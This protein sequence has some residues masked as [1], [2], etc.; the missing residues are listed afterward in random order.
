[1]LLLPGMPS[2]AK[3]STTDKALH[4]SES[5]L[6]LLTSWWT[7][8]IANLVGGLLLLVAGYLLYEF[9]LLQ[10]DPRLAANR[11]EQVI[12]QKEKRLQQEMEQLASALSDVDYYTIF[13]DNANR[14]Q[15][16]SEDDGLILLVYENNVL[17]F[18]SDH[19][20]PVDRVLN[21]TSFHSNFI[22]E[23]NGWFVVKQQQLDNKRIVGLI[24]IKNEY[25]FENKY[26]S[27][28]FQKDL[29]IHPNA[30][31]V[32]DDLVEVVPIHDRNGEELFTLSFDDASQYSGK[33]HPLLVVIDLLGLI[34]LFNFARL[35]VRGLQW[36]QNT[37]LKWLLTAVLLIGIRLP[38][39]LFKYPTGLYAYPLF[40][41]KAYA[42]STLFPSLGDLFL[43]ILLLFYLTYLLHNQLVFP[44]SWK[45]RFKGWSRLVVALVGLL[46]LLA[47]SGSCDLMIQ[48]LIDNSNISFNV[49]NLFE[50]SM[51]SYLGILIIGILLFAFFIFCDKVIE[52][53]YGLGSSMRELSGATLIAVVLYGSFIWFSG[54]LELIHLLWPL[55]ILT[56]I[57]Y[58]KIRPNRS[59]T[60]DYIIVIISVFALFSAFEL[61]HYTELKDQRTRTSL[62]EKISS[63]EDPIT[64]FLLI[65]FQQKLESDPIISEQLIDLS[66]YD[67]T[68]VNQRLA[69]LY[70]NG[71]LT[72]YNFR[73]YVFDPDGHPIHVSDESKKR[74]EASFFERSIER[75]A[76]LTDAP[77]LYF[78][79]NNT[80][81]ENYLAKIVTYHPQTRA[82]TSFMYLTLESKL[83]PEKLGFPELLLAKEAKLYQDLS[84]Y[85][86]AKYKD[87][88]LTYEYGKY[89]FSRNDYEFRKAEQTVSMMESGGFSHLVFHPDDRVVVVLSSE[90]EGALDKVTT[91][92][93]LFAFFSIMVLLFLVIRNVP[94]GFQFTRLNFNSKIQLLLVFV[95]LTSLALFGWGTTYYIIKQN[96]E[97]NYTNI[98]ERLQSV[99]IEVESKLGA[100]KSLGLSQ[101]DYMHTILAKFSN[102]FFTDINLYDLQGNLLSSSRPQIFDQGLVSTIVN[103][104]AF[105][106]MNFNQRS[107]FVHEE[108]I[109]KLT[110]LSAYAPFKNKDGKVL[111]YL[112][113]SYFA[114]QS[115]LE[116]EISSF[117]VALIN[118]YVF[119]F[120]LSVVAALLISNFITEPLR[121]VQEML[122]QIQLGKTNRSIE[123]DSDDEIGSLVRVY[124]EKVSELQESAE[125]LARSERESAW[126]EMAK[127]VAHEIKNPLT[128]MKLSVQMLQR[129]WN[130]KADD[131]EDRL[132]RFSKTIIEQIDTLSTIASEFSNFAQMPRSRQERMEVLDSVTPAID[133]YKDQQDIE[134][135]LEVLDAEA[136]YVRAD[137]EQ[138]LR[139]FNNLLK[140][141]RQAIPEDREGKIRVLVET[142]DAT[143][144]VSIHDNGSGIPDHLIDKIFAPNFTTKTSGMGL[145]L[146]MVKNIVEGFGG[147][148]R[149]ETEL[150]VGTTFF[151]ELPLYQEPD[152]EA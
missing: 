147:S 120:A 19:S 50:L 4:L 142:I 76:R 126:R 37:N 138:L 78:L 70:L 98:S 99:L 48:G 90:T 119:L 65:D 82:V 110:Y 75:Y 32:F 60:F 121:T 34:L 95:I 20:V 122:G 130:D 57:S 52:L 129:A 1:M 43:N 81:S 5:T 63:D 3:L 108:K 89:G 21:A 30:R 38:M 115:E 74:S 27:N 53:L 127:Q 103:P 143:A 88:K 29:Q 93:Y 72:K 23:R 73:T 31:I 135:T 15:Y 149:F 44:S 39:I 9:D 14:Y 141:A 92:S 7:H 22:R 86:F 55:G 148:V 112:N 151:V 80:T 71:Y 96:Q 25:P 26:L 6:D 97:K 66:N 45:T 61:S 68:T 116:R 84:Q 18:W 36:T 124:N 10:Q 16:L 132:D 83:I 87:H 17:R 77:N 102:V 145:G 62:A 94:T 113:V 134:I 123:Y 24:R 59:Y 140:N 114:K 8:K 152:E 56:I 144:R 104:E 46:L 105:H 111:A 41:P 35:L 150:D 125:L 67:G 64:E 139:V 128:P 2:N 109:G 13:K 12:H 107:T 85:S 58:L 40:S 51:Y 11:Y 106:Q 137:R 49:N 54:S 146:A 118:I 91:F 131:W 42:A 79:D 100:R 117:L 69:L 136:R 133:L 47:L 33:Q 28:T 101:Q